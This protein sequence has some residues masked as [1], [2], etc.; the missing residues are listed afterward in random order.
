MQNIQCF[1]FFFN[2][3]IF[4]I[5]NYC[6]GVIQPMSMQIKTTNLSFVNRKARGRKGENQCTNCKKKDR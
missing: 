1:F 3:F 4:H 6:P 2:S 5:V